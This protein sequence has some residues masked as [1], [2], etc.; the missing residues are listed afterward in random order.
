MALPTQLHWSPCYMHWEVAGIGK[1]HPLLCA[2]AAL[3]GRR[4]FVGC[5]LAPQIFRPPTRRCGWRYFIGGFRKMQQVGLW[6]L[7]N[8]ALLAV[9]HQEFRNALREAP[10]GRE[11]SNAAWQPREFNVCSSD[12]DIP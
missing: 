6:K 8:V 5:V 12:I 7:K 11:R 9:R 2:F 3:A 10:V 4:Y 1:Y